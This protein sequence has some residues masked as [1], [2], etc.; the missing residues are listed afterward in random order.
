MGGLGSTLANIAGQG[1]SLTQA[2]VINQLAAAQAKQQLQQTS[3]DMAYE[4]WITQQKFPLSGLGALSGAV[5]S[6][7]AGTKPNV[8]NP[9]SQPDDV[10]R[11]LAAIQ[12]AS[13]GLSDSSVQ[14]VID[15]LFGDSGGFNF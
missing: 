1:A 7:A 4:D 11:V 5:G 14:N 8:L 6:M 15:Y 13:S 9:I 3:L 2:D 12:A 10:S